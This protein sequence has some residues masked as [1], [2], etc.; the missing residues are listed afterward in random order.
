[1]DDTLPNHKIAR[2]LIGKKKIKTHHQM[3]AL[4]I[5]H[6]KMYYTNIALIVF[7]D[8]PGESEAKNRGWRFIEQLETMG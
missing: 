7:S 2:A 5:C 3:A 1:M 8:I 4:H 6:M